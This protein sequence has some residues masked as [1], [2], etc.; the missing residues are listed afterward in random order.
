MT[1]LTTQ[2]VQPETLVAP[3]TLGG[4]LAGL[5]AGPV[6]SWGLLEVVA[7]RLVSAEDDLTARQQFAAP[8]EHLKL[9]KC[10]PTAPSSCAT[11][12]RTIG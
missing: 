12:R 7:L 2:L 11:R 10:R 3:R 6:L 8:E 9:R 5:E 1:R 4:L